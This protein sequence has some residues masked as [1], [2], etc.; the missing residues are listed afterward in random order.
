MLSCK[1]IYRVHPVSKKYETKEAEDSF[2]HSNNIYWRLICTICI[3][4]AAL[5]PVFVTDAFLAESDF[6]F[7][8]VSANKS[9]IYLNSA[10]IITN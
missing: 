4:Q 7:I 1:E 10:F 8:S 3:V 5:W 2:I 6:I 9:C